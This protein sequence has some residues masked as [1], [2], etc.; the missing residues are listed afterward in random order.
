MDRL[1]Q[2]LRVLLGKPMPGD[3]VYVQRFGADGKTESELQWKRSE[4]PHPLVTLDYNK[5]NELIGVGVIG[6]NQYTEVFD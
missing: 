5:H 6:R 3:V 2:A 4:N 1:I